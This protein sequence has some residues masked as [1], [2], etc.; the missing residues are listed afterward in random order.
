M[1]THGNTWEHWRIYWPVAV[2]A[3]SLGE[4]ALE[5]I[6]PGSVNRAA[7]HALTFGEKRQKITGN[8][9][10]GFGDFADCLI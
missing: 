1:R 10:G 6:P 2:S 4:F 8:F 9:G 3:G 7:S 5:I